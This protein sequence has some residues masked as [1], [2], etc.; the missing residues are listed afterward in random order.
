MDVPLVE[1]Q[2]RSVT[3]ALSR[4]TSQWREETVGWSIGKSQSGLRPSRLTPR[5]NSITWRSR[6]CDLIT[7]RAIFDANSGCSA[8]HCAFAL[9]FMRDAV[10]VWQNHLYL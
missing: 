10:S 7:K 2:S 3:P 9:P 1:S 6:P 8:K 5:F 4:R